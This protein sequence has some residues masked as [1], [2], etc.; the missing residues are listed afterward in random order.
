MKLDVCTQVT[1]SGYRLH[2]G[3]KEDAFL[4]DK[5]Q[6]VTNLTLVIHGIGAKSDRYENFSNT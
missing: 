1:T 2:R 3:Y 6:P 5:S 4:E